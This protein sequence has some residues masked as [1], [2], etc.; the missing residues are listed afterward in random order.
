[1]NNEDD[2]KIEEEDVKS[3]AD[4]MSHDVNNEENDAR[5]DDAMKIDESDNMNNVSSDTDSEILEFAYT[6][7]DEMLQA[8]PYAAI[9]CVPQDNLM[10]T[11]LSVLDSSEWLE[12]EHMD[13]AMALMH[14]K[15]PSIGSLQSCG[16]MERTYGPGTPQQKFVQIVNIRN[17]HWITVSNIL[18]DK[19]NIYIYDSMTPNKPNLPPLTIKSLARLL[20]SSDKNITFSWVRVSQQRGGS[21][22]GLFA[23]ANSVALCAGLDP[24]EFMWDQSK[25]RKH[26]SICFKN[27]DITMFPCI[28]KHTMQRKK[29]STLFMIA[30]DIYCHCR[31]PYFET[32]AD[33]IM[34]DKC[35]EWYHINHEVV[36]NEVLRHK[37]SEFV[38]SVCLK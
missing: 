7:P 8:K 38:C 33:M 15:W 37:Q 26:L 11:M 28:T 3:E 35:F 23:I 1:V 20:M 10:S 12:M 30:Y 24:S 13:H 27:S 4:D 5:M 6:E 25:M 9:Y 34:C 29:N 21:D 19:S 31:V 22:C 2:V 17:N 16:T 14:N 32:D 18:C 36:S